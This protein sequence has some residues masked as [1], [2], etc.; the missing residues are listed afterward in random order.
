MYLYKI[1]ELCNL[2]REH[3]FIRS[4]QGAFPGPFWFLFNQRGFGCMPD[5]AITSSGIANAYRRSL[6]GSS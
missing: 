5:K 6:G 2:N 1:Y 4:K 3:G